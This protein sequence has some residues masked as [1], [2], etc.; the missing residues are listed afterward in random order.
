ME[1]ERGSNM[2]PVVDEFVQAAPQSL[3]TRDI[4][5]RLVP[6]T[7]PATWQMVSSY[8]ADPLS[9]IY[10][11]LRQCPAALNVVARIDPDDYFYQV[12]QLKAEARALKKRV[13]TQQEVMSRQEE[14]IQ[15]LKQLLSESSIQHNG[16]SGQPSKKRAKVVHGES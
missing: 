10:G 15:R 3:I 1:N 2:G 5:T 7:V 16:Q 13:A 6:F 11:I 4:T 14:E 9:L 12:Q 8:S